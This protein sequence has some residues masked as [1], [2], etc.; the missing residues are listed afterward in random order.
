M[1][2][3]AGIAEREDRLDVESRRLEHLLRQRATE[4]GD[5]GVQRELAL[6]EED[7]SRERETVRVE[8]ARGQADHDVPRD[9]V[10]SEVDLVPGDETDRGA[11]EVEAG[12]IAVAA[13]QLAHLRDLAAGDRDA[14]GP[15][16]LEEAAS[17][18]LE[19]VVADL[20]AGDVVDEGEGLRAD[21]EDVVDVHRD[22]VDRDRVVAPG[23][24]GHDD[25]RADAVGRDR[26]ALAA[27][28]LEDVRVVAEPHHRSAEAAV[29][30]ETERGVDG[31]GQDA[32]TAL[33]AVG[34]HAGPVVLECSFA[35]GLPRFSSVPPARR[36]RAGGAAAAAVFRRVITRAPETFAGGAA[37]A[38]R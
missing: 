1:G 26:E 31:P 33:G 30:A 6:L 34:V 21:A 15:R 22:H 24:F 37:P 3:D 36:S 11:D 17:E 27:R 38:W 14:R 29:V 23:E 20:A 5:V 8:T 4:L 19:D 28:Q 12:R 10:L 2:L 25:L 16:A 13:D 32:E 18:L 9:D 7:A 35:H